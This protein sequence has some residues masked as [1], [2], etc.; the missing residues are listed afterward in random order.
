MPSRS[1]LLFIVV[2]PLCGAAALLAACGVIG[3]PATP[4][5]EPP[6]V[7]LVMAS[8]EQVVGPNRISLVVLDEKGTPIEFGGGHARFFQIDGASAT[9]RSETVVYFRPIGL[10]TM[11]GHAHQLF[12]THHLDMKGLWLAEATFD[13]SGPWGVEVTVDQP[14]RPLVVARTQFDVLAAS[15]S[16]AV[17]APAPRSRN[18]IASDVKDISEISSAKPPGDMYDVRIADAVAAHRPLL[19]L[20][21]TPAFC[22]SRVCGP[23]YEI[24]QTVQPLYAR[25]MDFVHIEIWKDPIK[26]IPLETVT[27]WGIQNDPWVFLID[28]NGAVRYKLS[29]LVTVDEMEEAIQQT[30][31]VR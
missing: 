27:E 31:A 30:L 13:K 2:A 20:F 28:R 8:A 10:E 17:G 4:T 12:S 14:G 15:T 3:P 23:A 18:L 16:P 19:V 24:V 21:A 5:P 7:E 26:R 9:L 6:R 22:T 11:P 1:H 25:E 29:G